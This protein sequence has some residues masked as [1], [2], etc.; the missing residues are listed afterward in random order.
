MY[1]PLPQPT[2]VLRQIRS[3]VKVAASNSYSRGRVVGH[4][5]EGA[6][7]QYVGTAAVLQTVKMAQRGGAAC[8][9]YLTAN[10]V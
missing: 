2:I 10:A 9:P 3:E 8:S 4:A 1:R 5:I 6:A 7:L